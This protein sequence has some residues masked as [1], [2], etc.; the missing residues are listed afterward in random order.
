MAEC[1]KCGQGPKVFRIMKCAAC[2][3]PIC[4][5]CALRKHGNFFCSK[6]CAE[7]YFFGSGEEIQDKEA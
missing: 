5:S 2:F 4:E 7:V 3:K 6:G 1:A